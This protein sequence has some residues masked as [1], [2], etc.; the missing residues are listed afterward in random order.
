M[1]FFL[2]TNLFVTNCIFWHFYIE[3]SQ[4]G[5]KNKLCLDDKTNNSVNIFCKK[6]P[7]TSNS[8]CSLLGCLL[9]YLKIY[10]KFGHGC[11][12]QILNKTIYYSSIIQSR[13][14]I[15]VAAKKTLLHKESNTNCNESISWFQLGKTFNFSFYKIVIR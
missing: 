2:S 1:L 4:I 15:K 9:V 5:Y 10:K 3:F 12:E 6:K 11:T 14:A 8:K 13:K 7:I